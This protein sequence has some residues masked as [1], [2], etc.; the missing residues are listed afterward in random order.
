MPRN[1]AFPRLKSAQLLD[2]QHILRSRTTPGSLRQ[3]AELVWLLAGGASLAEASEWV[4]L[5]YTN[6][7]IWLRRFLEMGIAGLSDRPKS[8][9]PRSY[10]EDA[11]TEVIKAAAARPKDLGLPFT[12]W[13][14]PKL[15]E[16]L[17]QR[18]GLEGITRSTIRRRLRQEGFRF[19]E[20]Q[21]WCESRDPEFEVKK[22]KS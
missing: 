15:Q 16:Y 18:P 9:R 20:G 19:Y 8:G 4:G 21:T 13:S 3:R 22:T 2:L 12:T 17:R 11:T 1:L 7:H 10:D 14:L 5:H 6:A